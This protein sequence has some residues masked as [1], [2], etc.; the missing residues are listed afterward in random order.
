MSLDEDKTPD[1]PFQSLTVHEVVLTSRWGKRAEYRLM[2]KM[3][4][5]VHPE[6]RAELATVF[7]D[8]KAGSTFTV[9]MKSDNES[10]ARYFAS[11]MADV[12]VDH[13]DGY[14]GIWI[15]AEGGKD[16]FDVGAYWA[17]EPG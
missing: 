11:V 6:L 7:C 15:E 2:S 8:S 9:A 12:L 4:D 14:N 3:V 1:C 17:G 5:A 13:N 16:V 10:L